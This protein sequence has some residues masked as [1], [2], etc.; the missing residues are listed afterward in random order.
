MRKFVAVLLIL[1]ILSS[2]MAQVSVP[3]EETVYVAGALWGPATTWN[4]Y[5]PQSTWGTDQ[6]M[7]LPAFQYDLGRDAWI[8][9]IAEKYEFLDSTTLR[10]YIRPQAKWSDGTPITADDFVYACNCPRN[11][12]LVQGLIGTLTSSM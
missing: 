8:P 11:L 1:L 2:L 7:Y 9:T 10:I 6:F 12:E 4:L 3:R 5:A